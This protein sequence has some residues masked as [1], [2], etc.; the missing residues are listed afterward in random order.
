MLTADF[1][2]IAS[3]SGLLV[4]IIIYAGIYLGNRSP[5][6]IAWLSGWIV[7]LLSAV[8]VLWVDK[9]SFSFLFLHF[10]LC[11]STFLLLWGTHFFDNRP[12]SILW[13]WALA[14]LLAYLGAY[15]LLDFKFSIILIYMTVFDGIA[16][17]YHGVIWINSHFQKKTRS[18]I[19]GSAFF[20]LGIY[21]LLTLYLAPRGLINS[22][23]YLLHLGLIMIASMGTLKIIM[24]FNRQQL[25][26]SEE[27]FRRLAENASDLVFFYQ[28]HPVPKFEYV[29]PS[30]V[31]FN[32]YTPED[33][34]NDPDLIYKSV[35]P[36][37]RYMFKTMGQNIRPVTTIWLRF[38]HRDG[39]VIWT[40]QRF[41]YIFDND[42]AVVGIQGIIRDV[43]ERLEMQ[44]QIEYISMHDALTGLYNRAYFEDKIQQFNN[45]A[46]SPVGV[47]MCDLDGLKLVNDSLGHDAG[48]KLLT[49]AAQLLKNNSRNDDIPARIGGD[50][51]ALLLP[52]SDEKQTQAIAGAIL[53]SLEDYNHDNPHSLLSLSV[54]YDVKKDSDTSIDE[55]LKKADHNMYREKLFRSQS[56]HSTI[57]KTLT[58]TLKE[59][60]YI[61]KTHSDRLLNLITRLGKNLGLSDSRIADMQLLAKFHDIGKVGIPDRI[62]LKPGPLNENEKQEMQRH[63]E[64]GYRLAQSG[65]DLITIADWILKHHEW[66][67]GNGYPLGLKGEEIPLE[68]RIL[69]IAD[70]YDAMISSRPYRE[71]RTPAEA[72]IELQKCSGT[73]FDPYLVDK[74]VELIEEDLGLRSELTTAASN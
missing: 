46:F 10:L 28:M 2:Q 5:Y 26:E 53:K 39:H 33:H 1:I 24:N 48:D 43:T 37:D 35:H 73:Q 51:F 40:E 7:F 56:I 74:F 49:A 57:V 21:Y 19:T 72:V 42:G 4:V 58:N 59:R 47:I 30:V 3:L 55:T 66:W 45:P 17:I 15:K 16:S 52:N 64:I 41:R 14:I 61:T 29:S 11:S 8:A 22:W 65:P 31:A 69:A 60:D 36:D 23:C 62:L 13:S 25:V 20:F 6:I 67:D 32:G 50:E 34:Y 12:F 68:C 38:V 44:K 9:F 63:S 71:G 54:G 18:L 70:A 27:R